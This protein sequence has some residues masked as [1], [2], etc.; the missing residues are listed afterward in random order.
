M[1]GDEDRVGLFSLQVLPFSFHVT[2][3]AFSPSLAEASSLSYMYKLFDRG[4]SLLLN[5]ACPMHGWIDRVGRN[6]GKTMY[7]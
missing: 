4:V 6:H 1:G 7:R 5:A 2:Y 3:H